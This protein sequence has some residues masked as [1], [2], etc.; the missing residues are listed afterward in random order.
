MIFTAF[1]ATLG[2]AQ[3]AV[4]RSAFNIQGTGA[5][6]LGMGGAFIAVADDATAASWNPAGL[7]QLTKPEVSLVY[8]DYSGDLKWSES[9]SRI[10]DAHY[11]DYTYRD[12]NDKA[13]TSYSSL[14]FIS[15]TYP[16]EIGNRFLVT[17]FSY[18]KISNLPDFT[19]TYTYDYDYALEDGT[20]YGTRSYS[21]DWKGS[22]SG[23]I[24]AYTMSL[25]TELF[26]GFNLGISLNYM[27]ADVTNH[28][29]TVWSMTSSLPGEDPDN[30]YNSTDVQYDFKD[31]YFDFGLLY[32]INEKF[33]VGAVYHSGFKTD[34]N[35]H[36]AYQEQYHLDD[37]EIDR[38]GVVKWPDGWGLGIAFRPMQVLTLAADYSKTNWSKG[39][40]KFDTG[41]ETWF[42][43]FWYDDDNHKQ[44]DTASTR[45]GAEYAMVLK[46]GLVIP[47]RAGWFQEDQISTFYDGSDQV[48]MDGYT[49]GTGFTY[50][51]FQLDIA[52]VHSSGDEKHAGSY[53]DVTDD[54]YTYTAT[55]DVNHNMA[56]DRYLLSAI[57][58]F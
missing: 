5:R 41:E 24:N 4:T 35:Y 22:P 8:D 28:Y 46:N 56:M 48:T 52:Y 36:Y 45:V 25:A 15:A 58:R 32:K 55:F 13:T 30:S 53:T 27:K 11:L 19:N 51:N 18:N 49:L 54:G 17:Q 34:L 29:E 6:A 33:S 3:S 14:S 39:R 10:Y 20:P 7:A 40:V 47:F 38:K 50:K 21:F 26:T 2:Y 16:F 1:C 43:Y 42:P 31:L 12:Y 37:F 57:V 44:Y 23:G 9:G